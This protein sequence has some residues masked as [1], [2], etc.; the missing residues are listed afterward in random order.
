MVNYADERANVDRMWIRHF[1]DVNIGVRKKWRY[2]RGFVGEKAQLKVQVDA[3]RI[4]VVEGS[5][6]KEE[7]IKFYRKRG[8]GKFN[9]S[10]FSAAS[11]F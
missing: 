6:Q 5:V 2:R 8:F 10:M 7:V 3:K 4:K 11:T 1:Y 9:G